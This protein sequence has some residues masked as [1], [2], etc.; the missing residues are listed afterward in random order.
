MASTTLPAFFPY[1]SKE[2]KKISEPFF[3][4][5]SKHAVKENELDAD[6][7]ARAL[8]KCVGELK[9]YKACMEKHEKNKPPRRLRVSTRAQAKVL[10]QRDIWLATAGRDRLESSFSFSD[11]FTLHMHYPSC[12]I[13][14]T[15]IGT[16]GVSRKALEHILTY[17]IGPVCLSA[18]VSARRRQREDS[19]PAQR[20]S[21]TLCCN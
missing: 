21:K 11:K 16:G 6:A 15:Y 2:C 1:S 12:L 3:D 13:A 19:V 10:A 17:D 20:S 7:G 18:C 14:Y 5:L 9:K 8:R 4:C